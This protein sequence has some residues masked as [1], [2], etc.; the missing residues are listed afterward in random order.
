MENQKIKLSE[1]QL[2]E[3]VKNTIMESI[4]DGTLDEGRL[5]NFFSS[6]GQG[7]KGTVRGGLDQGRQMYN[8]NMA[9]TTA[10]D[11]ADARQKATD[12]G[13]K[14]NIANA[15]IPAVQKV[16][17]KYDA[18]IQ[19]ATEA[20]EKAKK[21]L[22]SL[23]Q[24]KAQAVKDARAKYKS[25]M[26]TRMNNMN[27]KATGLEGDSAQYSDKER[28]MINRRRSSFGLDPAQASANKKMVAE[29]E[30]NKMFKNAFVKA[31]NETI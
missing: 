3:L 10:N 17:K 22:L 6:L 1:E 20:F 27:N 31:L 12:F 14:R 7:I 15:D 19:K 5:G 21:T 30:F 9:Q 2:R 4:Q 13:K 18:K 26:T 23:K 11:A 8:Q 29:S 28:E 25:D 16:I 24:E